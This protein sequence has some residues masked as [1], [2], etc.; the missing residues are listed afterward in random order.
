MDKDID[1]ILK[2]GLGMLGGFILLNLLFPESKCKNCGQ[3]SP[4]DKKI[5]PYCGSEK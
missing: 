2:I 1:K 3:S 5:C 4:S